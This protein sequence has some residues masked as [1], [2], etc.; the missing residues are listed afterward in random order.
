MFHSHTV[1]PAR[2]HI[3]SSTENNIADYYL[4]ISSQCIVCLDSDSAHLTNNWFSF[5]TNFYTKLK[6]PL[7]CV[8]LTKTRIKSMVEFGSGGGPCVLPNGSV[9]IFKYLNLRYPNLPLEVPSQTIYINI[10]EIC[11]I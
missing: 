5:K 3:S 1:T 8:S 9:L 6:P 4:P 11:Y 10:L 2:A 7:F